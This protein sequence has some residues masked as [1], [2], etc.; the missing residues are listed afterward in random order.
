MASPKGKLRRIEDYQLGKTGAQGPQG[1][2]GEQGLQGLQGP[3]GPQGI[4]GKDGAAGIDGKPGRDGERGPQGLSGKDAS[5]KD[6]AALLTED[7]D[8][9]K[10][11]KGR[12]GETPLIM[13][14][15]GH[16]TG[17]YTHVNTAEHTIGKSNL[18]HGMNVIGVDYAGA[19]TIYLPHKIDPEMIIV[20]NDES[21]AA[22]SNNITV[23]TR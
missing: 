23:T 19:V 22:S 16:A 8:F 14:G 1:P 13:G 7:E 5:P 20:I 15:G 4:P 12:D 2:I 10:K 17:S 3:V 6:V 21:G 18:F 9:L 11:T